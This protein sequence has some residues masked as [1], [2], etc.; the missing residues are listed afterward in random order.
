VTENVSGADVGSGKRI[1]QTY[2]DA[3]C[4]IKRRPKLN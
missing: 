2:F 1:P 4:T 3:I